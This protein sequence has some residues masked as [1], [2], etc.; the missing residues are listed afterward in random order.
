MESNGLELH[1]APGEMRNIWFMFIGC[2]LGFLGFE[3]CV[4]YQLVFGKEAGD[5]EANDRAASKQGEAATGP[6][7]VTALGV[8]DTS[9]DGVEADAP[10]ASHAAPRYT[11]GHLPRLM[12]AVE[13]LRIIGAIHIVAFHFYLFDNSPTQCLPCRLGE[14]WVHIFFVITGIV[15]YRSC[16]RQTTTRDRH[17]FGGL[18]LLER[19]LKH[20][21]PIV[22]ISFVIVYFVKMYTDVYVTSVTTLRVLMLS[23]SW[24]PPF[25]DSAAL[26][27]PA[28]Y[29]SNLVLFWPCLPHWAHAVRR[30][31]RRALF[32]M[33]A[34]LYA[35]S[36]APFVTR[37]LIIN[38]PGTRKLMP[39][40]VAVAVCS[41]S[42]WCCELGDGDL[43]QTDA[44]KTTTRDLTS[45]ES[46]APSALRVLLTSPPMRHRVQGAKTR[47][48]R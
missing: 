33:L 28:W 40:A 26:N 5:A 45:A 21:Y 9:T 1:F 42:S 2:I 38:V 8:T 22:F 27:G 20:I 15:S 44:T 32:L 30:A 29:I 3:A 43:Y 41:C 14:W 19:R 18:R 47:A 39:S 12:P 10:K 34:T 25:E 4:V 36:F 24:S 11:T 31:S 35:G 7:S 16:S 46:I 17:A 23:S 13:G 6:E 37:Y 48:T